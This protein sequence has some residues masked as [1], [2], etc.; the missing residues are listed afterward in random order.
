LRDHQGPDELG[1]VSG[2]VEADHG[3]E[4]VHDQGQLTRPELG[5]ERGQHVGVC[6]D[7]GPVA[8]CGLGQPGA[9]EIQ[10]DT[11]KIFRQ[12][13]DDVAPDERPHAGVHEQQYR[14]GADIG[15]VDGVSED[16]GPPQRKRP[17]GLGEPRWAGQ[18]VLI[19]G[20]LANGHLSRLVGH[21]ERPCA[22]VSTTTRYRRM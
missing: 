12:V 21:I 5:D 11:P 22:V 9:R 15:V 18:G 6:A 20:L 14:A 13:G 4:V 7:A 2:E 17:G 1:A 10:C 19:R 8:G 3:A 16:V